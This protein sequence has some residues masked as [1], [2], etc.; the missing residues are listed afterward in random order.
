MPVTLDEI[1]KQ[2]GFS[3]A[4]VARAMKNDRLIHP[5][6]RSLVLE[7]AARAGY[8]RSAKRGRRVSKGQPRIFFLLPPHSQTPT[9]LDFQLYLG[10]LTRGADEAD[11]FL[12]V[13]TIGAENVGKISK[14]R[15]LPLEIRDGAADVVV[16]AYKHEYTDIHAISK[17]L[18]IVSLQWDYRDIPMDVVSAFNS[19]GMFT[20]VGRLAARGHQ[21]L[22]W[23]GGGYEASFF[24]DRH[25]GFIKGCLDRGLEI[26]PE[27]QYKSAAQ[28]A[29]PGVLKKLLARGITGVVCANDRAAVLVSQAAEAKG[30]RIPE[31]LSLAGF[32]AGAE[33]TAG[34]KVISSYDPAISELGRTAVH[35]VMQR[36]RDPGAP[37]LVYM[38]EGR[39]EEGET[40]FKIG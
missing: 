21:R 25:A 18:P 37:R 36:L 38:R 17:I 22:A 10:G 3:K 15:H 6:T 1:A 11:C 8:E 16:T 2:V 14:R 28:L 29:E 27:N 5:E 34:G 33:P 31:D 4:T 19:Q 40:I 13:G 30:I 32:D 35:A 39:V 23:V 20:M 26:V 9:N 12:S 7:A 24:S